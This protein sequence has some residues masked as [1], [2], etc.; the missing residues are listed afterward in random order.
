M[1]IAVFV[2]LNDTFL[3]AFFCDFQCNMYLSVFR[4]VCGEHGKLD[5]I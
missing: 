4:R 2:I 3:D 5:S 1:I